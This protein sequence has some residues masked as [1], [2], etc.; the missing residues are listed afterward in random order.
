MKDIAF[1]GPALRLGALRVAEFTATVAIVAVI[2]PIWLLPRSAALRLGQA[3]GWIAAAGWPAAR[4][5]S[6]INLRRAYGPAITHRTARRWTWQVFG[7]LGMSIAEGLQFARRYR[8]D[9]S[10]WEAT[11]ESADPELERRIIDD[12]RPK[13]LVTGHLG[14]W[15][16]AI[17]LAGIRV[18]NRG[19]VV[20]R[21]IDN[22]FL[23]AVVRRIRWGRSTRWIEKRGATTEAMR[24]LERGG[25]VTILLDE[26]AGRRGVFVDFLG[27]PAATS[28]MAAL[29]ALRTGASIVMGAA[30]RRPDDTRP[31]YK[32][33]MLEP[34]ATHQDPV[35]D[36][37]QRIAR[38]WERWV[39]DDPLQWR[40][41]HWRWQ[42]RP[43]G[44]R[45]TYTR[46][47]VRTCFD[48]DVDAPGTASRPA[49][50][51]TR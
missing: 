38:T 24:H 3:Y 30:I 11:Y 20:L 18:A 14:S 50:G 19:A 36:L 4:R 43:D 16:M 28:K 13:I 7:H 23:D 33:A 26:S 22:P 12:P 31:L 39:L 15:E 32:L 51:Q 47:D 44:T 42:H 37:T 8:H 21:R 10:G 17:M 49:V 29:L 34:D 46:Q 2:L 41:I 48:S 9:P 5:V 1:I 35:K 6:M 45:E 27:R 40:W 25:S